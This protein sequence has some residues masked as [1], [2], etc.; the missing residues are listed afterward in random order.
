MKKIGEK[1]GYVIYW[2]CDTQTY[3]VYLNGKF[4]IGNKYKFS[5]VQTYIA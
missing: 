1:N 2:C 5:Q 4:V 3:S